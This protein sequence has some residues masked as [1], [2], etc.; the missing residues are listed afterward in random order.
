MI[1]AKRFRG[2]SQVGRR[3]PRRIPVGMMSGTVTGATLGPAEEGQCAGVRTLTLAYFALVNNT[4]SLWSVPRASAMN[5]PSGDQPKSQ[6]TPEVKWVNC[7]G[8]PPGKVQLQRLE[9]WERMS[10]AARERPSGVQRRPCALPWNVSPRLT[11]A[12]S[13]A[14]VTVGTIT[15]TIVPFL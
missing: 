12:P 7:F 4:A 5:F 9:V 15:L 3:Q 14:P 8:G 1:M 13:C 2:L 6:T 11:S 10:T